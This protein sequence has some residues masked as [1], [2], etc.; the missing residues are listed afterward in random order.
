[1]L[2]SIFADDT[3][4][5]KQFSDCTVLG[6]FFITISIADLLGNLHV[7]LTHR[8]ENTVLSHR[9]NKSNGAAKKQCF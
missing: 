8:V 6:R 1:M 9:E 2:N 4:V 7:K 5:L 3:I